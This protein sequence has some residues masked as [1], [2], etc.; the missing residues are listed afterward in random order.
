MKTVAKYKL[1]KEVD[2]ALALC[3]NDFERDNATIFLEQDLRKYGYFI[4]KYGYL[5]AT[6]VNGR[7]FM[8]TTANVYDARECVEK[9]EQFKNR[10]KSIFTSEGD[11]L[12]I[13]YSY[14]SH[15]PMFIY[16]YTC[17]RWYANEDYYSRTTSKQRTQLMPRGVDVDWANT[18]EMLGIAAHGSTASW[19]IKKAS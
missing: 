10:S 3:N 12:Y 17:E 19:V 9:R 11:S 6:K 4:N 7:N 8:K 2:N 1:Q 13:V 14:G 15:Y 18:R 5:E 16:D